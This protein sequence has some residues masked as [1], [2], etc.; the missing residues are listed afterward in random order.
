LEPKVFRLL[1]FLIENRHRVVTKDELFETVWSGVAVTDNALTRS[2]VKL[3]R[4]LGDEAKVS[5]FIETVPKVGYR[6]AASLSEGVPPAETSSQRCAAGPPSPPSAR[7]SRLFYIYAAAAAAI[8]AIVAGWLRYGQHRPSSVPPISQPRQLTFSTGIEAFPALSPAGTQIAYCSGRNGQMEI[9]VRQLTPSSRDIQITFDGGGS[10]H[11]AWSAGGGEIA[12]HN[13]AR[14]GIWVVPSLGGVA[15]QLTTFGSMPAW[16]PDNRWIAFRSASSASVGTA[17]ILASEESQI[18]IVPAAGGSPR[19]IS[20]T[21]QAPETH[22]TPSWS[23]D[24]ASIAFAAFQERT[25][26]TELWAVRVEDGVH[27]RLADA[28]MDC[29]WPRYLPGGDVIAACEEQGQ[30]SIRRISPPARKSSGHVLVSLGF[31]SPNGISVSGDGSVIAWSTASIVGQLWSVPILAGTG[32]P[33]GPAGQLTNDAELRHSHPAISPDGERVAYW[34]RNQ[35]LLNQLT[36]LSLATKESQVLAGSQSGTYLASWLPQG[37]ALV[38]PSRKGDSVELTS[39]SFPDLAERKFSSLPAAHEA[40]RLSPDGKELAFHRKSGGVVN[41][42]KMDIAR[43]NETQLTFDKE[44][45]R[46]GSWSQDG[47]L[48]SVQL[49]RGRH[50]HVG[51]VPSPGGAMRVVSAEPGQALPTSFLPDN[52]RVVYSALRGGAWNVYWTSLSNSTTRRV[53]NHRT[54]SAF[55][56]YPVWSPKGDRMLF[57]HGFFK[58][59]VFLADLPR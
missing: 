54:L 58:G 36:T 21:A 17:D 11:P 10:L 41:V 42:W 32:L 9:F 53:T 45:A 49:I 16:S 2:V 38:Y 14:G 5:R 55:L 22:T 44:G 37:R 28:S 48:I 12:Y 52:D 26:A 13:S 31:A 35:M 24:G 40:A 15:R 25:F 56:M 51:V 57:E 46:L 19:Q 1:V 3:R 39:V 23:R 4:A 50:S 29:M 33:S 43:G 34:A 18:W 8:L 47:R 27:S 30:R 7:R 20:S 6:F 59:N